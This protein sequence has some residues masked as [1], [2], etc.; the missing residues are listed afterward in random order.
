MYI[1]GRFTKCKF[2]I[3]ILIHVFPISDQIRKLF[4]SLLDLTSETMMVEISNKKHCIHSKNSRN[5]CFYKI[6]PFRIVLKI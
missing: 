1:G 2:E 6:E 4:A 5:L 3:P